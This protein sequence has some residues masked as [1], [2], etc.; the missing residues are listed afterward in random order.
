LKPNIVVRVEYNIV[1]GK[2]LIEDIVGDSRLVL[3][4]DGLTTACLT[5][6]RSG[7][8]ITFKFT[9]RTA[10]LLRQKKKD[11]ERKKEIEAISLII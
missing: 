7:V 9:R 4:R 11:N 6:N 10:K 8:S 2:V 3:L 1:G 5:N